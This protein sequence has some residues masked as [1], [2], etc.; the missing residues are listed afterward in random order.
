MAPRT[1]DAQ[2]LPRT[3]APAA[4][5]AADTAKAD[6][7][8]GK[9]N[10]LV[11]N[12]VKQALLYMRRG[13]PEAAISLLNNLA[14]TN[15]KSDPLVWLALGTVY[16][17][18]K[19]ILPAEE[20]L[21]RFLDI[22][23]REANNKL[24]GIRSDFHLDELPAWGMH[25]LED[26]QKHVGHAGIATPDGEDNAGEIAF[27]LRLAAPL[28]DRNRQEIFASLVPGHER[29]EVTV[30]RPLNQP[31]PMP[32]GNFLFGNAKVT[33]NPGE[34]VTVKTEDIAASPVFDVKPE[35]NEDAARTEAL[36]HLPGAPFIGFQAGEDG[37]WRFA[38]C[39]TKSISGADMAALAG[40]KTASRR[41]TAAEITD[42]E[43]EL[44]ASASVR[45]GVN[46]VLNCSAARTKNRPRMGQ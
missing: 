26:Y 24:L 11:R 19:D 42:T 22:V 1:A 8:T 17:E 30:V 2:D 20:A 40:L 41:L 31:L 23:D 45:R 16:W 32:G 43:M 13:K 9:P 14:E 38:A 39:N 36:L 37:L 6:D 5:P 33:V 10:E 27:D 18:K 35:A 28:F 4:E 25:F 46:V 34:T 44:Y 21:H 12:Q 7:E 15:G 3:A 29:G